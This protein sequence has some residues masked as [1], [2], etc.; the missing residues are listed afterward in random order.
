MLL[1]HEDIEIGIIK[2][3][4]EREVT[5][6]VGNQEVTI[7]LTEEEE[8]ELVN[9][10]ELPQNDLLIPINMKTRTICVP[11]DLEAWNEET[12]D[13]LIEASSKGAENNE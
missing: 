10:I 6:E 13:E 8:Q 4:G 1:F 5:F 2:S 12:M 3:I 11:T 9:Y 7:Q